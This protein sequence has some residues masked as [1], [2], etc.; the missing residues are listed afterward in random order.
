MLYAVY[1]VSVGPVDLG[2]KKQYNFETPEE[3]MKMFALLSG[4]DVSDYGFYI[5][6]CPPSKL[7]FDNSETLMSTLIVF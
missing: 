7:F 5:K 2:T 3:L 4:Q 6:T 1:V